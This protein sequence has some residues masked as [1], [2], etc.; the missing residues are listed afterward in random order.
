MTSNVKP[1]P[2]D[3]SVVIPRLVCRD[4]VAEIDFCTAAFD[5][6]EQVRRPGP[7]GGV[8]HALI[9]IGPAMVMIEAEFKTLA[10]RAPQLDG[11]SPVVSSCMSKTWTR[12]WSVRWPWARK[13]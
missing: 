13:S 1:I 4:P 2:D 10:N 11:S 3:S 12:R 5:A 8:S 9:T 6:E 7:D